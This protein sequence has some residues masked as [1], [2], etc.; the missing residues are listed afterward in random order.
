MLANLLKAFW[1]K[2]KKW[3]ALPIGPVSVVLR[4][5]RTHHVS[6]NDRRR[7]R[8]RLAYFWP[9]QSD[10]EKSPQPSV[11]S[12]VRPLRETAVIVGVGPGLGVSLARSL[13]NSGMN[14]AMASRNADGLDPLVWDLRCNSDRKINAYG[15]DATNESSVTQLMKYVSSDIGIPNLVIYCT[16]AFYP[17]KAIDVE[18]C[19]F[20]ESWRTNCLG[21]FICCTRSGSCHDSCQVGDDCSFGLNLWADWTS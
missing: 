21:A 12:E 6:N 8:E 17:G 13:V 7:L 9:P 15:C 14:L 2:S 4:L 3:H 1:S 5:A 20:E 10:R 11:Q 19:A 16:Q 18:V